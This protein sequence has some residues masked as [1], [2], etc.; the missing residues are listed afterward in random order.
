LKT[1]KDLSP[2]QKQTWLKAVSAM[3]LKNYG[4]AIQICQSL[5]KLQ[6]EFLDAR[7]LARHAA[8]E[9]AKGAKKGF[10]S[11]LGGGSQIALMKASSLLKKNDLPALLP[12]LEEILAD[13]PGNLQANTL[14]QE[15]ALRWIP[16]MK[17]LAIF[18]F[19][20][21]IEINPKEKS[22]L[23]RYAAFCLEHD[24][25]D[26]PRNPTRAVE[27]YNR[28]LE[29]DPNDLV[30]IKGSKDAAAAHS[31][32]D[33]GWAVAE[34]YRDLIKDKEQ[35]EALEQQSR[36][37][38]SDDIIDNQIAELSAQ[39]HSEPHNIDKSRRIAELYEKKGDYENAL[40]WFHYALSISGGADPT[41]A[42]KISNIKLSQ[43]EAAYK[44]REEYLA[45]VPDDPDAPRYREEMAE[46]E[47]Q[48]ADFILADARERVDRNPTDLM[49]HYEL[50]LALID[51]GLLQEAIGHLQ[52]ARSNPSVRLRAMGKLGEC[53]RAR[54][55]IDLAAKTFSDAIAE[56]S[57]MDAM[58]KDLLYN[59]GLVYETMGQDQKSIDCFKQIYEVDYGYRDVATR[60]ESSYGG[61]ANAA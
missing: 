22:Q 6:P 57:V 25:N 35:A 24:E 8:Q 53:Y 5:L 36:V 42:R 1:Q 9:K 50:A 14:L 32:H 41:I 52:R 38:K 58:K 34:S 61:E 19:E 2:Q 55:M 44:A 47:K 21:I 40:E 12:A 46:L 26:L 30:A 31:V 33:G 48:R 3:E 43:I 56:L 60:V 15:A 16:P 27:L 10:L 51:A 11:G 45:A 17:E 29:L 20:T 37:I 54:N 49:A 59:L 18:A 7:K 28:I 13:D 39:V 4:Y 23:Y